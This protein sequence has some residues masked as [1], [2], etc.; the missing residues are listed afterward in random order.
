MC[1]CI[2]LLSY[3]ASLF[4]QEVKLTTQAEVDAFN[5]TVTVIVGDFI[6]G[7]GPG[8]FADGTDI[9]DLS[10]LENITT[11]TGSLR[12]INNNNLSNINSL[13]NITSVGIDL[14]VT[15]NTDLSDIDAF[16]KLTT[17]GGS[18][19]LNNLGSITDLNGISN[20]TLIGE[21]LDI[22]NH[23]KLQ[24]LD[25]LSQLTTVGGFIYIL[26]NDEITNIDGLSNISWANAII[27]IDNPLLQNIN[28]FSGIAKI[29]EVTINASDEISNRGW[30]IMSKN[31]SL[32]DLDGLSNLDTIFGFLQINSNNVLTNIDGLSSLKSVDN[33]LIKDNTDLRNLDGL[34][35]INTINDDLQIFNNASLSD[36]CGISRIL[37]TPNA[38]GDSIIINNNLTPCDSQEEILALNC[39]T[40][41]NE[42]NFISE[43][44]IYPNPANDLL[45]VENISSRK[46]TYNIYNS[47]GQI[48]AVEYSGGTIDLSALSNGTYLLQISD[49]D[50]EESVVKKIMVLR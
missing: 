14:E 3:Q 26:G 38:I 33:I 8:S 10:N 19:I 18:L 25:D 15:R 34:S 39:T 9:I 50:T 47:L 37:N 2:S 7:G 13:S 30:L 48:E 43:I 12:I 28:G 40:S 20:I 23:A 27:L 32:A 6:I 21:N 46:L 44:R 45:N 11:I 36:C 35:Q 5:P 22:T 42:Y 24:N 29:G 17:L 49:T 31:N 41:V 16:S 1:M 4:S